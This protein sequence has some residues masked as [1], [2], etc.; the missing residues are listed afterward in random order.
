MVAILA[1]HHISIL[2]CVPACMLGKSQASSLLIPISLIT[3]WS[4]MLLLLGLIPRQHYSYRT[5]ERPNNVHCECAISK[6]QFFSDQR[7]GYGLDCTRSTNL[8]RKGRG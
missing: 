6:T 7:I 5:H 8:L 2:Y 3:E 4:N 1:R